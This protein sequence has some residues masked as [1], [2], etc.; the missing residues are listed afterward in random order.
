MPSAISDNQFIILCGGSLCWLLWRNSSYPIPTICAPPSPR[1]RSSYAHVDVSGMQIC[2]INDTFCIPCWLFTTRFVIRDF[3]K[4][5]HT[6][7]THTIHT[8]AHTL[9]FQPPTATTYQH[10]T[11]HNTHTLT[12]KNTLS[13]KVLRKL[14]YLALRAGWICCCCC[15]LLLI[16]TVCDVWHHFADKSRINQ[17]IRENA[18][19]THTQ[20]PPEHISHS[21]DNKYYSQRRR[22]L[23]VGLVCF[24]V[25]LNDIR[26]V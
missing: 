19:L 18:P 13:A 25:F 26:S 15:C 17:L 21:A 20:N 4:W 10:H 11:H 16:H 12:H 6:H 9:R 14:C 5:V 24:L 2:N 3:A 7:P 1:R 8:L 22:R 23:G